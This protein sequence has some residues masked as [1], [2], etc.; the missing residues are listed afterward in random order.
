MH[1]AASFCQRQVKPVA[2]YH[3]LAHSCS[4]AIK[5]AALTQIT[6]QRKYENNNNEAAHN[7]LTTSR[8]VA[9]TKLQMTANG[10]AVGST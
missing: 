7:R 6:H 5:Y 4:A 1:V 3:L 8:K 2:A 9:V 10:S